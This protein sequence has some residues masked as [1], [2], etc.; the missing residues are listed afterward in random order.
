MFYLKAQGF[1]ICVY[2]QNSDSHLKTHDV[3]PENFNYTLLD[4]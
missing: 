2:T 4:K 1:V 3:S